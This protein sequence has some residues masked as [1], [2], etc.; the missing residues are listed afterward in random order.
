MIRDCEPPPG[1]SV[2]ELL[3]RGQIIAPPEVAA[4]AGGG[5]GAGYLER[6]HVNLTWTPKRL[7][8]RPAASATHL[9]RPSTMRDS[10]R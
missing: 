8:A 5:D 2:Q 10:A 1:A 9:L 4:P 3:V 6:P 7:S